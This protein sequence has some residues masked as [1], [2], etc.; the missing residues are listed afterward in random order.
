[1]KNTNLL[2]VLIAFIFL[3]ASCTPESCEQDTEVLMR[4]GFFSADSGE[5]ESIDSLTVYGLYIPDSL[6]YSMVTLDMIDLPLNPSASSCAFVIENGGRSDTIEIFYSSH[7][8]FVS[9]ACGYIYLH[10]L[11]NVFFTTNDIVNIL[12][13]GKS[14]NPGNEQ[15]IQ[16]LF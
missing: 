9:A 4:A 13:T 11:E 15:N 12:I 8:S 16:I 7:L 1:M 5:K 6:I 14:V 2:P 10:E 3:I